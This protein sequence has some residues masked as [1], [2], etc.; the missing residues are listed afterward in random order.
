VQLRRIRDAFEGCE[1]VW[2]STQAQLASEVAPERFVLIPDANRWGKWTLLR[3]ALR[4]LVLVLRTRP[5]IVISSG[6]APGYFAVR[7]GRMLGARTLW[8]DS[9]A[10]AG[11]FSL[12][13]HHAVRLV[14]LFL[15]QWPSLAEPL[16]PPANRARGKPYY[17]G[18]VV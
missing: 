11:E 12:S 2:A 16:P 13:G 9:I 4:V 3:S 10:N 17:A 18:E 5:E 6:A 15:S 14:D 8:L 7:F 1:V